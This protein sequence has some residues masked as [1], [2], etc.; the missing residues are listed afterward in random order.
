MDRLMSFSR[1]VEERVTGVKQA[2]HYIETGTFQVADYLHIP[3]KMTIRGFDNQRL[4]FLRPG[5]VG[6]MPESCDVTS[7]PHRKLK[8][9][10]S[11][12]VKEY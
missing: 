10:P 7:K 3:T 2:A 6:S 1:R 11:V 5:I 8:P 12:V 9:R 4:H